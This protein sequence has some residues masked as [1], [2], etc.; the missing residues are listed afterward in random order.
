MGAPYKLMYVI[1]EKALNI[2]WKEAQ[3]FKLTCPFSVS[4]KQSYYKR[5]DISPK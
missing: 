2:M 4:L 1:T 5:C 3:I